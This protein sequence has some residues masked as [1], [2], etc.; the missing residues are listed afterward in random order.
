MS[1]TPMTAAVSERY[2]PPEVVRIEEVD[3][4]TPKEHELLVRVHATTVNRTDCGYRSGKPFLIKLFSGWAKPKATILG[5]EYAGVVEAV[6]SEVTR[7]SAGNRV[8]GYCEGT[9]GAH[10]EYMTIAD[11][12]L[13]AIIPNDRTFEQAA[14]S[15]EGSH[16]ALGLIRAAGMKEGDDILVYGATGAI[17]SAAVQIAKSLGLWVTA[18]CGTAH[19]GLVKGL[20]A[21][22]VVDYQTTDFTMDERRYDLVL[23]AVGKSSFRRC[24]RLLKP[25][26]IYT[27]TDFGRV[28]RMA[29][30]II[31][32]FAGMMLVGL[33]TRLLGGR[34]IMFVFPRRDP[35]GVRILT[36]LI[37]SGEFEP[38][39]DRVYPLGQIVDAYRY[40]ETGQKIG[41]VVV[42]P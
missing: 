38:L 9:F 20:G 39:I 40:A 12:R 37:E 10:A 21:D 15:T 35:E 6:G 17:G 33:V 34:R 19:V 14:P 11:H 8:C 36:E 24:R 18:V 42:T 23:D 25:K 32:A 27:R 3:R 4:P 22:K 1:T 7:F 2:G 5:T 26:G 41:N 29:P 31:P 13:I 30:F 16:Y 28:A